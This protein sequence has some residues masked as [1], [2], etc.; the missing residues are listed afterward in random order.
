[1]QDCAQD[2]EKI[3]DRIGREK[4]TEAIKASRKAWPSKTY[5]PKIKQ[6]A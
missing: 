2:W 1:M 3:T 6:S 5:T 4:I